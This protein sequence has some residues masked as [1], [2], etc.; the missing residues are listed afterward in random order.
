MACP[1]PYLA[2]EVRIAVE[3]AP[4]GAHII[5]SLIFRFLCCHAHA[6]V[7]HSCHSRDVGSPPTCLGVSLRPALSRSLPVCLSSLTRSLAPLASVARFICVF[8]GCPSRI[9]LLIAGLRN[10]P[11]ALLSNDCGKMV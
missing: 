1:E 7:D 10:C 4:E 3:M 5:A 11:F 6:T 2:A 9:A 8:L